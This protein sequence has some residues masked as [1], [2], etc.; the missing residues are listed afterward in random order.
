MIMSF[1]SKIK[2]SWSEFISSRVGQNPNK[3]DSMSS[4][5]SSI[6]AEVA[7]SL[8]HTTQTSRIPVRLAAGY[9]LQVVGESFYEV[10][11]RKIRESK[12]IPEGSAVA[13]DAELR[14]EPNTPNSKSGK[15]VAVYVLGE[16][17]GHI[18]EV[19]APVIHDD[20]ARL[21]GL[22]SCGARVYFDYDSNSRRRNSVTL[23]TLVP[24]VPAS[25]VENLKVPSLTP[26]FEPV[27]LELKTPQGTTQ[28]IMSVLDV[29]ESLFDRFNIEMLDEVAEVYFRDESYVGRVSGLQNSLQP[30]RAKNRR[31]HYLEGKI[32]RSEDSF[33]LSLFVGPES[34][35]IKVWTGNC[36]TKAGNVKSQSYR[37]GIEADFLSWEVIKPFPKS[38]FLVSH[39]K[40]KLLTKGE[41]LTWAVLKSNGEVWAECGPIGTPY[42]TQEN[43]MERLRGVQD[44]LV[45]TSLSVSESGSISEVSICL[46]DEIQL[47]PIADRP[48]K[49]KTSQKALQRKA[50]KT[51]VP[52]N[53]LQQAPSTAVISIPRESDLD[54]HG[55]I[56]KNQPGELVFTGF[57]NLLSRYLE[58]TASDL[59]FQ[60][61][62]SVTR[63]RTKMLIL[64]DELELASSAKARK[65][66]GF[67][68][69]IVR[70]SNWATTN[71]E[72][73]KTSPTFSAYERYQAWLVQMGRR[74]TPHLYG[75]PPLRHL[76]ISK[77][78]IKLVPG[79]ALE[80]RPIAENLN[81]YEKLVINQSAKPELI[82]LISKLGGQ[83]LDTLLFSAEVRINSRNSSNAVEIARG[84]RVIAHLPGKAPV[85]AFRDGSGMSHEDHIVRIDWIGK[86]LLAAHFGVIDLQAN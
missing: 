56:P 63:S 58:E 64:D 25:S 30:G 21:G 38:R 15:A 78:E 72:L 66:L 33:I 4:V 46:P 57:N 24:I 70:F 32:T 39:K 40:S 54:S 34:K 53:Q 44:S 71:S 83:Q 43:F 49:G 9:E 41:Y 12:S 55:K 77:G 75:E 45:M 36:V 48:V 10:A 6:R 31:F 59:G 67:D 84:G 69:P 3:P 16:K 7:S 47:G 81:I 14:T 11:F 29:G 85:F 52:A 50:S 73:L 82:A 13:L 86:G 27:E 80:F 62:N 2:I 61:G 42:A 1:F 74:N 22:A 19:L 23:M 20:L 76:Q 17:V 8:K 68:I 35:A 37:V 26:S 28:S 18:A 5:S 60:S 51:A 79:A 65:A